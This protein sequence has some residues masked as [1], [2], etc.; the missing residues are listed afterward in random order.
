MPRTHR[1]PPWWA[2]VVPGLS[3][4]LV[5]GTVVGLTTGGQ[6]SAQAAAVRQDAE[7]PT[8]TFI[9]DSWTEGEGATGQRG[10]AYLTGDRLGWD[11]EVLG[12][13]GSGYTRP[14]GG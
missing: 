12:V 14:G 11:Y 1:R 3:C 7:T 8:V 5:A 10:Y 6:Q 4:A 2:V 9:G 13:G